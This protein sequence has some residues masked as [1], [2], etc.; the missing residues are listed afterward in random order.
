[1][2]NSSVRAFDRQGDDS[3]PPLPVPA[4][5]YPEEQDQEHDKLDHDPNKESLP[6]FRMAG[7]SKL[8]IQRTSKMT[9]SA[10]FAQLGCRVPGEPEV[11]LQFVVHDESRKQS[12]LTQSRLPHLEQAHLE[13]CSPG[14]YL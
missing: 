5:V 3:R 14:A 4:Q 10:K 6:L 13:L 12:P 2:D 7:T 8:V 11:C 1:M 9:L